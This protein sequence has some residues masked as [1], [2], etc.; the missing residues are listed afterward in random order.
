MALGKGPEQAVSGTVH[1]REVHETDDAA[2]DEVLPVVGPVSI[3][4]G[5]HRVAKRGDLVRRERLDGRPLAIFGRDRKWIWLNDDELPTEF[6]HAAWGWSDY[7]VVERHPLSRW[8]GTDF[9]HPTGP[10]RPTEMLGRPAWAVELAPPPHKPFPL[11]MV[12]D[13]ETGIVLHE[14]NHG[15]GSVVEWVE[16]AFGA[17]LPDELFEWDGEVLAHP[18]HAAEHER[19]MSQRSDWLRSHG[20]KAPALTLAPDFVLHSWDDDTG[21]FEASMHFYLSAS[22]LRRLRSDA[23]WET[24]TNWPHNYR[25]TDDTFDWF[26]GSGAELSPE[27]VE[28][29]RAQL[30]TGHVDTE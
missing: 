1:V 25:W 19:E 21:A 26:I 4:E 23:D 13:A 15:F 8:E 18:D 16:I 5:S 14:R 6:A 29:L 30:T 17:D 11:T 10:I 28:S 12:V 27:Q 9:T 7:A 3:T 22:V 20:V 2:P 24:N